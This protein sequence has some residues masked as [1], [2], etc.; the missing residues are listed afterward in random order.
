LVAGSAVL[1]E[2]L[3]SVG[4]VGRPR[5]NRQKHDRTQR[6]PHPKEHILNGEREQ[7]LCR[8]REN[9]RLKLLLAG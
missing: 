6:N 1:G 4:I 8:I 9:S 5:D 3:R 7:G 2:H